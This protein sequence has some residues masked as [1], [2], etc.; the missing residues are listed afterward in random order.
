MDFINND[1]P[2]KMR[3]TIL[4]TSLLL[5]INVALFA[6]SKNKTELLYTFMQANTDTTI[7]IEQVTNWTFI[8]PE[9]YLLSKKGD[10]LTCYTYRDLVYKNPAAFLFLLISDGQ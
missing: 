5:F 2:W 6:Q 7:V 9:A 1:H 3:I 10:T 8:S 4:L